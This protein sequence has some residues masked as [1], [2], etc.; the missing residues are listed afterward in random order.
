[1]INAKKNKY[2]CTGCPKGYLRG[3]KTKLFEFL[4]YYIYIQD[5]IS[6]VNI[7]FAKKQSVLL[8]YSELKKAFE[9][10]IYIFLN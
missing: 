9:K 4:L 3:D 1:M 7:F 5:I 6:Y 2:F 10:D 8:K